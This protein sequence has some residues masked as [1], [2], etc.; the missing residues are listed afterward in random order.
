MDGFGGTVCVV[1][2]GYIGLPTAVA[3]A[4]HGVSVRG[5]D[6]NEQVVACISRGEAPFVEADLAIALSGA[7]SM[8][9]LSAGTTPGPA[10]A[11]VIAVPTPFQE[12]RSADLRYVQ[13]A[14]RSIAP[15]LA[16]GNLVVLESTSPPGTTRH[17]SEWL[18]ELRPDLTFPHAVRSG[19]DVA[20]AHCPE[21]V[22]PGRIM[23][24]IVTN[25]RVIGGVSLRCAD[26]ARD[27]YAVFTQGEIYLTDATTAEM[28]KLTENA[29]RDVNIAFANELSTV[30]DHLDIDVHEVIEL[31]NRH[32]R[33]DVLRPGPGVGGHCIAVDPWFIVAA[34]PEQARLIR[35]AREVND[36]KPGYVADE[37]TKTAQRF[38]EPVIACLG[39]A[40]KANVD[41]VRES[42]ALTVVTE[43][44]QRSIGRLLVADPHVAALPPALADNDEVE[45]VD[46][47]KAID[48]ADIVVLLVD[49]DAFRS[50]KQTSLRGKVVFDTRGLWLRR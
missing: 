13:T 12:D 8:G 46:M 25:D 24:E 6:I 36:A 35:L 2:L 15:V 29:F 31:A 21:R 22:L 10:D 14:A 20:I 38:R 44:A 48:A 30:C 50:V 7:V 34:A 40:Y 27:L 17:L 1:G 39:L 5:V 9:R 43:L 19:A 16:A 41:D 45:L 11:F 32:P 49:H 37:V 42:P 47:V 28:A 33:V 4:T 26:V 3:L 23:I 18:A